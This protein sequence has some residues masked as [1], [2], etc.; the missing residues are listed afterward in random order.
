L[1]IGGGL[2]FNEISVRVSYDWGITDRDRRDNFVWKNND[3]KISL[4]YTL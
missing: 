4:S 1:G 3:L 2:K